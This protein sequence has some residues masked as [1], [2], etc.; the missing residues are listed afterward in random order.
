MPELVGNKIVEE[1]KFSS[2]L[3]LLHI[4]LD[5]YDDIFSDFDPTEYAKRALSDDFIKEIQKRYAETKK[6]DI[7]L[8]FTVPKAMRSIKTEAIIKKRLKDYFRD[9]IIH[10]D[11]EI[12]EKKKTGA[13]YFFTGFLVLLLIMLLVDTLPDSRTVMVI[14]ILLTPVGWFGMWEGSSLFMQAPVKHE[15]QKKFFMKFLKANYVFMSEEDFLYEFSAK[16]NIDGTKPEQSKSEK[17][18]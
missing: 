11:A 17:R 7:E 2:L 10:M 15:E 8:R 14:G 18:I 5:T 12:F 3:N 9:Q 6:G 13:I 1:K 16:E 4:A